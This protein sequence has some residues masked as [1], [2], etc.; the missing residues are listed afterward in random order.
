M[1]APSNLQ[2]FEY[3][4]EPCKFPTKIW[5]ELNKFQ[6]LRKIF[7]LNY[8]RHC[9]SWKW[10][11]CVWEN[12]WP[13]T[14]KKS[15]NLV[16]LAFRISNSD[17]WIERNPFCCEFFTTTTCEC[18]KMATLFLSFAIYNN[19]N[20]HRSIKFAKVSTNVWE[21]TTK[22]TEKCPKTFKI[23]PK[24]G[25]FRQIWSHCESRRKRHTTKKQFRKKI[26]KFSRISLKIIF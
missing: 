12:S 6:K 21:I 4:R 26:F 24:W 18:D 23:L 1:T 5:R 2:I 17:F 10:R 8:I 15:P 25:K 22:A 9:A 20:F 13:K 16:T 11:K 3:Q 7:I 14:I 19:E